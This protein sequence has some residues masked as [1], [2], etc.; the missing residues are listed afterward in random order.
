MARTVKRHKLWLIPLSILIAAAALLYGWQ[1]LQAQDMSAGPPGAMPGPMA[2]GPSAAMPGPSGIAGAPAAG[3][4]PGAATGAASSMAAAPSEPTFP[5]SSVLPPKVK[6]MN[7]KNWDGTLTQLLR[8]KYKIADGRTVTVHLPVV[9]KE[10]KMTK[11]GWE[12]LF[13]VFSMDQE[14]RLDA[15]EKYNSVDVS[16]YADNVTAAIRGESPGNALGGLTSMNPSAAAGAAA[17]DVARTSLPS[18]GMQLP[19]MPPP[20]I[21]MP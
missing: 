17:M 21:G 9:Y 11:A 3:G 20:L 5:I 14:A 2:G 15:I 8:F 1:Q 6:T 7:I 18:M 19:P 10:E 13:Q 4:M 12:T 16:A